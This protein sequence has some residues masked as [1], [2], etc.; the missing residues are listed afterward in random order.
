MLY[1]VLTTWRNEYDYFGCTCSLEIQRRGFRVLC[2]TLACLLNELSHLNELFT[3]WRARDLTSEAARSQPIVDISSVSLVQ[4][5]LQEGVSKRDIGGEIMSSLGFR[6]SLW[7]GRDQEFLNSITAKLGL[8]SSNLGL[9][10]SVVLEFSDT[11]GFSSIT[12]RS[13]ILLFVITLE[14]DY[15]L[16]ASKF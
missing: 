6:L 9:R 15:A 8:F 16:I 10:N 13:I 7:N 3:G 14:P 1:I 12:L 4:Y 2:E 5:L 11:L